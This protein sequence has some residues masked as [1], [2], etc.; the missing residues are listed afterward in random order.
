MALTFRGGI[1]PEENKVTKDSPI[2]AIAARN[3]VRIPLSQHIGAPAV[4]VVKVGDRVLR[5]AV[6][7]EAAEGLSCPIH[8]SVSGKV[9]AIERGATPRGEGMGILIENDHMD[10]TDPSLVP[11]HK[12][13]AQST[14]EEL[15]ARI[16]EKGIVG[17][18]GATFPLW[19]KLNSGRGKAERLIINVAECEPYLTSNHRLV[20]EKTRE[21]VDGVKILLYILGA[22]KCI[23]AVEDNKED[24][25]DAL[26][27]VIQGSDHFAVAVLK[28]KYPQGDERQL[29][30]ALL[31]KEIPK[32][33]LPADVGAVIINAETC[34]AVYRAFVEGM[35]C[36]ERVVTVSGDCVRTPANLLVPIGMSF[37]EVLE[38]CGGLVCQPEKLI[39]GGPMM[40]TAQWTA[41]APVT[42]GVGGILAITA[43][44]KKTGNCIHCGRCVRACPMHLMP[45]EFY[46]AIQGGNLDDAE[47]YG[48]TSC[49]ECGSCTFV[50]PA[51]IPILQNIRIG[52]DNL[53]NRLKK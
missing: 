7:A 32:G 16:K 30:R 11:W 37:G 13:I 48:I 22:E 51:G 24:A 52:K 12:P 42:R 3:F 43:E 36:V 29:I 25:A 6:I 18:G 5:G 4:P 46:R 26:Q 44:E 47:Y 28:T 53:R 38:A 21:V 9:L 34:W 1:H 31:G 50:C 15:I 45:L 10:E 41:D 35:P 2:R 40:G 39:S 8:S 49:S 33:K 17:L 14:P 19:A 20:L 27:T 23:F